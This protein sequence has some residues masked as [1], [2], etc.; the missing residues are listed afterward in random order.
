MTNDGLKERVLGLLRDTAPL[1]DITVADYFSEVGDLKRDQLTVVSEKGK[2]TLHEL[3]VWIT[4]D[5]S[6]DMQSF[7]DFAVLAEI[8][9]LPMNHLDSLYHFYEAQDP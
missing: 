5:D 4:G 3:L 7:N 1:L 6:D 9:R 8:A 2:M